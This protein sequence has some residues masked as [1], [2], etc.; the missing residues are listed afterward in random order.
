MQ[1]CVTLQVAEEEDVIEG[2]AEETGKASKEEPSP[3]STPDVSTED[4]AAEEGAAEAAPE[5]VAADAAS[6]P[7]AHS[8]ETQQ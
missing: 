2:S 8:Q 1:L 4:A 6:K 5:A 7:G 3:E